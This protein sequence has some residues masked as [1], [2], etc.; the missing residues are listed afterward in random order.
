MTWTVQV[1]GE[2]DDL[3]IEIPDELMD[4]MGWSVGDDLKFE[5][6]NNQV[7]ISKV[8]DPTDT[9]RALD[10]VNETSNTE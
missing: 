6:I 3:T 8:V 4:A 1:E 9:V 10:G 7:V 5:M 2:G